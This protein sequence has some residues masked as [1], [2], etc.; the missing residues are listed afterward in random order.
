MRDNV[1]DWLL[2]AR[3][4][5]EEIGFPTE[6]RHDATEVGNASEARFRPRLRV[7]GL[8]AISGLP[9]LGSCTR[10]SNIISGG[11]EHVFAHTRVKLWKNS[12]HTHTHTV[13]L[14]VVVAGFSPTVFTISHNFWTYIIKTL[15]QMQK[16]TVDGQQ[17]IELLHWGFL[18]Y[19]HLQKKIV[20]AI[21]N[22][23]SILWYRIKKKK[24]F[25][26]HLNYNKWNVGICAFTT[27]WQ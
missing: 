16:V 20:Y 7:L 8:R 19:I 6:R 10:T 9:L 14:L 13:H 26:E 27:L 24:L 11:R 1:R 23:V 22:Q 17:I 25:K 18:F 15:L 21:L 3:K 5:V 4:R 2:A 12:T